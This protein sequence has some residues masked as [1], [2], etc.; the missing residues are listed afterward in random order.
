[1]GKRM[2]IR[3]YENDKTEF[4][5]ELNDK[6]EKS[7]VSFLNSKTG[8]DI[9][10]GITDDGSV[11]GLDN[12][13]KIQ[14]AITDRIKNNILPSSLGLFDVYSEEINDRMVI[15]VIVSSGTEKPYYIK[16][17]GMSPA[18]CYIRIGSG[19]KQMDIKM[20]DMFYASRTR[21]SLR[22]IVSPRYTEH[23][24]SQ[25]KIYY[26]EK[27]FQLNDVF[28]K[29]LD[30]Y[31]SDG[32][33]NYVAYLL[34]DR[35]SVSI[36]VAKYA[37]T[38]KCDLIENEEYGFCSI[39]KAT[40][41]VLDKL[42]IE[43]KTFTKITGEAKRLE[44]RMIDKTALRE[45]LINALV[46]NDY[47]RE[48]AP[49]IEIFSDRLS[50][51]SYGGLIEGLSEEEFF[52]GRSMPRNRE[53]MRI[54]KDL[55]LVE[56]LGSGMHR[57]LKAY[58]KSI[59][60]LSDNFLEIV[61]PFA[62]DYLQATEQDTM[63]VTEQV[64]EQ[65]TIQVTVQ[66]TIQVTVQDTIQVVNLLKALSGECSSVEIMK[67]INLNNRAHFQS[68]YLN[69]AIKKGYIE[70]TIPEKPKSR[71]QKYRLTTKGAEIRKNLG[72]LNE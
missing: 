65:D 54:F 8:G 68:E 23:T 51:T 55:E 71:L 28:L 67:K 44:R 46:H 39:I 17:L 4:K 32:K 6:F 14:L 52:N 59:F 26:E 53:L 70:M 9:Y 13:D 1:M 19:V 60:K 29:N 35:N 15:H 27:G 3:M 25:L 43:N 33:L 61:F 57:I 66:D 31:T 2:N 21:N 11:L 41:R 20:I 5:S 64:T 34:A 69:P 16:S 24:F 42:E 36:K 50:I 7:V 58:D 18:G 45:A 47:S 12:S 37:G 30:L 62:N 38:D 56:H 72:S 49:V 63:Q 10:I 48:V 22:N 40:E